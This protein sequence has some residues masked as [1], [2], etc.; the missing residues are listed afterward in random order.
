MKGIEGMKKL[1]VLYI[2]Y[3]MFKSWNEYSKLS[4]LRDTL[5]EL[6]FLGNPLVEDIE[7]EAYRN[8]AI[9]RLPFLDRFDGDPVI[10][11][12]I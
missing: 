9:Q 2:G 3:N 5:R 8:E 11:D 4:E 7:E 12:S 10:K 6:I 1:K